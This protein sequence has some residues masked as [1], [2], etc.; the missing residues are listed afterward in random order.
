MSR[1]RV[2]AGHMETQCV[3]TLLSSGIS[4]YSERE[5]GLSTGPQKQSVNLTNTDRP[6][7]AWRRWSSSTNSSD[8]SSSEAQGNKTFF[9]NCV[10]VAFFLLC[11]TFIA[12]EV[13]QFPLY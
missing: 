10:C 2:K 3:F 13:L 5:P 4:M 6:V 12:M 11:K 9:S 7:W 1:H 8:V